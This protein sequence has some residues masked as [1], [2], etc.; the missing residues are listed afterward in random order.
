V[1]KSLELEV[2][3]ILTTKPI[4]KTT[5]ILREM[6]EISYNVLGVNKEIDPFMTLSFMGLPVIPKLKLTDMG[7]F[8]VDDFKFVDVS[9][10]N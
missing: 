4:E 8:N 1:L 10:D 7:L 2:G 6:M 9:V 5:E 3:G